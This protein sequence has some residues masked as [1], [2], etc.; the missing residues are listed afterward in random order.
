MKQK[1]Q[2]SKWLICMAILWSLLLPLA[3]QAGGWA[4][5][6]VDALPTEVVAE[7]PFT[8]EFTV[9]QHGSHLVGGLSPQITAV[10][11]ESKQRHTFSATETETEGDYSTQLT[12]PLAGQWQ[13][14]IDAFNYDQVMPPLLVA[15]APKGIPVTTTNSIT[16]NILWPM[17]VIGL[18]ATA[19][20]LYAWSQKR[21]HIR[22]GLA[23]IAALLFLASFAL[24]SGESETAVAQ[25]TDIPA[26][27]PENMAEA[28]F[29]S[30]GCITCHQHGAITIAKNFAPIGPNLTNYQGNPDYLEQWLSDPSQI[31]PKTT[32]PNLGLSETEIQTLIIF[33]TTG[34]E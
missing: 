4:V 12:L 24:S 27:A 8:I 18:L 9:L 29:I 15:E 33:L 23:F 7:R 17:S 3:V 11:S 13:W 32:M 2:E 6:T 21:T 5:I 16:A 30:K 25:H 20:A 28:I 1:L 34:E 31:K 26:I 19:V 10:H 22:L 14:H